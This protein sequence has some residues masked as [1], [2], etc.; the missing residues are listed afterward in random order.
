MV[1]CDAVLR[2]K[3]DRVLFILE[4]K[5]VASPSDGWIQQWEH[6]S[7]MLAN[8][9]AIETLLKEPVGGVLIEGIVKGRRAVDKAAMSPFRGSLIQQ[10]VLC[11]G[12]RTRD[13]TTGAEIYDLT[14][15]AR[16]E[17]FATWEVMSIEKWLDHFTPA[18]LEALFVLVP[19]I[20]PMTRDLERWE[21]QTVAQERR[22]QEDVGDVAA[23]V[24]AAAHYGDVDLIDV[25][26]DEKFPQNHNNCYRYFGHPCA[27]ER[28]CFNQQ[29][30]DDPLGS[31]IYMVRR[32]HHD[33][34][35]QGE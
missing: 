31:G 8:T 26:L 34:E 33:T 30:S 6:N 15:S 16:A 35:L 14:W 11:Y 4:F 3:I 29:V 25:A 19:P 18:D 22:I 1:R 24:E 32:P 5:S 7:Q 27:F 21:R 13:K 20:R 23:A 2:R 10:N 9:R 12:Y 28:L 17:K